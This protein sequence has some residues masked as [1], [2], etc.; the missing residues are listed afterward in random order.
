LLLERRHRYQA[1][2]IE[3][4][5]GKPDFGA[6]DTV[7]Y[8]EMYLNAGEKGERH[9]MARNTPRLAKAGLRGLTDG[10]LMLRGNETTGCDIARPVV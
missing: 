9:D 1:G 10:D 6:N 3:E 7:E 4:C 8:E 5:F 2:C